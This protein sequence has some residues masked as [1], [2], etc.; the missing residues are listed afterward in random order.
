MFFFNCSNHKFPDYHH[1]GRIQ[2]EILLRL[3]QKLV[4]VGVASSVEIDK[5]DSLKSSSSPVEYMTLLH[6]NKQL[7]TKLLLS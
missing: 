4:G 5:H 2:R 1:Q 7:K 6:K 3:I